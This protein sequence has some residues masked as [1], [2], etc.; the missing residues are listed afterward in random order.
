LARKQ[1]QRTIAVVLTS[2]ALQATTVGVGASAAAEAPPEARAHAF[3]GVFTG[4]AYGANGTEAP[5]WI[6]ISQD[7]PTIAATA[8]LGDGMYVGTKFC[9]GAAVPGGQVS[10][11]AYVDANTPSRVQTEVPFNVYG[12]PVRLA[13]QGDLSEDGQS[14]TARTTINLPAFC[15]GNPQFVGT[16]SRVG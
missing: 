1:A 2:V 5:L 16:L 4:T 3:E 14:L 7:G 13:I 12:V 6:D 11:T 10:G 9:G 15:G 8:T